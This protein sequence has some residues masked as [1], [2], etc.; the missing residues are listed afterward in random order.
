MTQTLPGADIR[1][2]YAALDVHIPDWARTEATVSCFADSET[3]RRGDRNPSCSVNLEH[4]A[5]HCHGCGAR[6]G[7][8]DAATAR[9]YSQ[10]GAIDLMIAYQ[11]TEHRAYR[12]PNAKGRPSS[13][14]VSTHQARRPRVPLPPNSEAIA[15]WQAR[16]AADTDLIAKLTRDRGWLYATMLELELGVD[17]G[18]ITVP[19]RD[20]KRR[21]IGLLRYQP[22]P[23]PGEPKMLA[24]A[25]SRRGLLPHPTAETS[26]HV[27]LVEGEPD[28]IAARSRGLPA[29]AVPGS[30]GWR[31]AWAQLFAG[32]EVTVLMDCDEQG[33]A[34]AVAIE[35]DLSSL[36][37]V[38]VHD[39]A[40]ERNDGYDLTD[41][42]VD[43]GRSEVA[44]A[45]SETIVTI[46]DGR[47]GRR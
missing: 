39:I 44:M 10:R 5:W 16:L 21:P 41:W 11:L 18:R 31:S 30:D 25:G 17:R 37:V 36:S 3:H 32:R 4:G 29:I 9:G 33:R 43:G 12:L 22:W 26:T 15:R 13:R 23:H 2:Y 35:R 42:L 1:G 7:A 28:M 8:F 34:A 6:G 45:I 46:G 19:V 40:P 20:D 47:Y 27:L 24:T 38:R 14:S